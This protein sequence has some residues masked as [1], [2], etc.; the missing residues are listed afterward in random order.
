MVE[1]E[2]YEVS[3]DT[4]PAVAE[5]RD[6]KGLYRK[7]RRGELP[8]FTGIDSPYEDPERPE[9]RI[10]TAVLTPEPATAEALAGLRALGAC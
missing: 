10:D 1:N 6:P 9:V 4:P 7:A 2:F 3:V 5:Q 8:N